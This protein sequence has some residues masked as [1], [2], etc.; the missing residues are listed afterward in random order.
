MTC[1]YIIFGT[2]IWDPGFILVNIIITLFIIQCRTFTSIFKLHLYYYILHGVWGDC[3]TS[4]RFSARKPGSIHHF[5]HLKMPVPCQEYDSSCPFV[6]HF[7]SFDFAIWLGTF[8]ISHGVQCFC[9]FTFYWIFLIICFRPKLRI[10]NRNE[11]QKS[12]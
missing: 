3:N 9:D 7:L 10:N 2:P 1:P 6:G 11:T 8:R 4:E 5:L 12:S